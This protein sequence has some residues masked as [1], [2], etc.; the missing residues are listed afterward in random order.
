MKLSRPV[1]LLFLLAG[2]LLFLTV[3]CPSIPLRVRLGLI[4]G[5]YISGKWLL[6]RVQE[7]FEW[8]E[9]KAR[10]WERI[11]LALKKGRK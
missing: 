2:L 4:I 8:Q 3:P 9:E 1:K 11:E 5:L 10:D 6:P 7:V